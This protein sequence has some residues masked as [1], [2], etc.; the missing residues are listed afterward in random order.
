M[1]LNSGEV[2]AVAVASAIWDKKSEKRDGF[3]RFSDSCVTDNSDDDDDATDSFRK[4]VET[5]SLRLRGS[6]LAILRVSAALSLLSRPSVPLRRRLMAS[7]EGGGSEGL[8]DIGRQAAAVDETA[9]SLAM[10]WA[11]RI[12]GSIARS[13][14]ERGGNYVQ[15]ATVDADG[16]PRCRT[17]VFRGFQ[18]L[19]PPG[20]SSASSVSSA[21]PQAFRMITDARSEKVGHASGSGRAELV[22]WFAKS[23]EQYRVAGHLELVGPAADGERAAA[24]KA[25]WGNL[26][27]NAR[28]Q[29]YWTAQPGS[30]VG[31]GGVPTAV[32]TGGRDAEGKVL[33]VPDTFLLL[34][35]W[36]QQVGPFAQAIGFM[37]LTDS[38]LLCVLIRVG[39]VPQAD[40]QLLAA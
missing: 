35:L 28:E 30:P 24:R 11:E 33:P 26:S 40:R 25:Q 23:S 18:I 2:V 37:A 16:H 29:F 36:P 38:A 3:P 15:L 21:A 32:P 34:L 8:A 17:V 22:W 7:V 1:G 10:P 6:L 20:A 12:Q 39:Q 27:D 13:R 5:A 19:S 4:L 31:V 9:P 14:K